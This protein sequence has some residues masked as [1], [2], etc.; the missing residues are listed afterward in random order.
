[1]DLTMKLIEY[2]NKHYVCSGLS[3]FEETYEQ[4]IQRFFEE[5]VY[6]Q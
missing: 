1:M 6:M 3:P 4:Q 5:E 2:L